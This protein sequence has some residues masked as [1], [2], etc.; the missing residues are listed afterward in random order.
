VRI[1]WQEATKALYE[2]L[3][4]I[5]ITDLLAYEDQGVGFP[6]GCSSLGAGKT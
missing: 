5:T 3:N 2:K 6:E 4:S 1:A